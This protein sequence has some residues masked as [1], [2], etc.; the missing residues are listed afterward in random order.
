MDYIEIIKDYQGIFYTDILLCGLG[1]IMDISITMASSLY[2]LISTNNDI[3]VQELRK[4]GQEIS[5]DILRTMINVMLFTCYISVIPIIILASKNYLSIFEAINTYAQ[6]EMI[7]VLTSCI[8]IVLAIPISL[9]IS[10]LIYKGVKK[11]D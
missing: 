4:S 9:Y 10:L 8:S 6:I 11:H 1:A 3:S 2:E 5:K 7:R